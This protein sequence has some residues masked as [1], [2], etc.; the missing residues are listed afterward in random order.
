MNKKEQFFKKVDDVAIK[1]K[2][3]L[4]DGIAFLDSKLSGHKRIFKSTAILLNALLF[5]IL[6]SIGFFSDSQITI[7]KE[8]FGL[9]ILI[10]WTITL[11]ASFLAGGY[12]IF[13][14]WLMTVYGLITNLVLIFLNE[15]QKTFTK[16]GKTVN[17]NVDKMF[18]RIECLLRF[19]GACVVLAVLNFALLF[20]PAV[21]T[22]GKSK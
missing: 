22:K 19:C 7:W 10:L 20:F 6:L 8:L 2:E 11:A 1:I 9:A 15:I 18:N 13:N 5:V 14:F 3:K 12:R 4:N 17:Y 21:F 16:D